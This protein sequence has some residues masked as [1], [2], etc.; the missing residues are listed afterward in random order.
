MYIHSLKQEKLV[1]ETDK[2]A[3]EYGRLLAVYARLQKAAQHTDLAN[4]NAMKAYA[5]AG[6]SPLPMSHRLASGAKNHLALLEGGLQPWFVQRLAEINAK[7]VDLTE[8]TDIPQVFDTNAQAH[9]DLGFWSE[10]HRKTKEADKA[11][12]EPKTTD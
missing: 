11:E 10:L 6:C 8:K 9:F 12:T 5:S 7:I 4:T 2:I 1:K 3:F